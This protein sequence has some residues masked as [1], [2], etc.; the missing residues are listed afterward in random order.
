LG[1]APVCTYDATNSTLSIQCPNSIREDV[2]EAID[3]SGA[4]KLDI[5]YIPASP[6]FSRHEKKFVM[7]DN[8][9]I[10]INVQIQ[11]YPVKNTIVKILL[12]SPI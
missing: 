4:Y 6:K 3:R 7:P 1:D 5:E 8:S 9:S 11:Y 10:P 2:V 12:I